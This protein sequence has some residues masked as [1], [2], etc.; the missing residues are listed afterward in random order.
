MTLANGEG[1]IGPAYNAPEFLQYP[2]T[3]G[4]EVMKLGSIFAVDFRK[5]CRL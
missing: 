2:D 3:I 1:S 4:T 5:R